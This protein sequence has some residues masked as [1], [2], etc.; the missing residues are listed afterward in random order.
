VV[1]PASTAEVAQVVKACAHAA[2][3]GQHRAPGRQHRLVVGSTPDDSG[4]QMVLS[5]QRMNQVR[6]IDRPT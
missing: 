4:T 5:L 1:R 2:A 3:P 6:A